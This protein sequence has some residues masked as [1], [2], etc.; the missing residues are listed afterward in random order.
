MYIERERLGGGIMEPD[1]I[2][3]VM[4]IYRKQYIDFRYDSYSNNIVQSK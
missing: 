4:N 1:G 3:V 2:T